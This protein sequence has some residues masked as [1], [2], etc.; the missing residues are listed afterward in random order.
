MASGPQAAAV[1][2]VS[3]CEHRRGSWGDAGELALQGLSLFWGRRLGLLWTLPCWG[4]AASGSCD[5][6]P[7]TLPIRMTCRA[8]TQGMEPAKG[9]GKQRTAFGQA[10]AVLPHLGS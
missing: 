3:S 6:T 5:T 7:N 1:S 4:Q 8:G 10:G 2:S 9:R